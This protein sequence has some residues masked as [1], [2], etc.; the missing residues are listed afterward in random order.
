MSKRGLTK[1]D[2]ELL[3]VIATL[4]IGFW[5]S[6]NVM[7]DSFSQSIQL[8][9]DDINR[10]DTRL[11]EIDKSID[12]LSVRV[13]RIEGYLLAPTRPVEEEA[14]TDAFLAR[15]EEYLK[16]SELDLVTKFREG[17]ISRE[18]AASLIDILKLQEEQALKSEDVITWLLIRELQHV[19]MQ[20]VWP[21][22]ET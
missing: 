18:E 10:L 20:T 5:Q 22:P 8:L 15:W 12:D 14:L 17:E 3:A 16:P 1:T 6:T 4:I 9:S 11:E 2:V 21:L 13:A 19:L 7:R